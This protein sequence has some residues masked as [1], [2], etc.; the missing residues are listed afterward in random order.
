MK[1]KFSVRKKS[2]KRNYPSWGK[3][4]NIPLPI[5]AYKVVKDIAKKKD[6]T[7]T[8]AFVLLISHGAQHLVDEEAQSAVDSARLEKLEA[9]LDTALKDVLRKNEKTSES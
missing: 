7:L 5:N 9:I 1:L 6:L 2:N 8:Q 4:K 3:R